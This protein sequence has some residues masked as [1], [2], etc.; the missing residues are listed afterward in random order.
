MAPYD[1]HDTII[2]Y[3]VEWDSGSNGATFAQLAESTFNT[4]K[5]KTQVSLSV[6]TYYQFKVIAV[7]AIG[8]SAPSEAVSLIAAT[9]PDA[10]N[11]PTLV[12]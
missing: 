10:P 1:G 8:D 4:R 5:Y 3:R 9:F 11:T 12:F 2:D 7:N 6:G